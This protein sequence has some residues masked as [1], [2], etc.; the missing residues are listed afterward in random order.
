MFSGANPTTSSYN[1]SVLKIL[2]AMSNLVRFQ[3]INIFLY[4]K[5]RSILLQRWRGSCIIK[6]RRIGSCLYNYNTSVV[7]DLSV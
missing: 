2:N 7:V 4:F 3:N 1:A 5:K 6:N